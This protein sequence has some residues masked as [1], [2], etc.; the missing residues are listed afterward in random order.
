MNYGI[1]KV[2]KYMK[3]RT[4]LKQLSQLRDI[5]C[6]KY[7]QKTR[8]SEILSLSISWIFSPH[9]SLREVLIFFFSRPNVLRRFLGSK[10]TFCNLVH[11]HDKSRTWASSSFP[12]VTCYILSIIFCC[13][14]SFMAAVFSG[15]SLAFIPP[16]FVPFDFCSQL[17]L[18]RSSFS[19]PLRKSSCI[20]LCNLSR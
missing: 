8:L 10:Y 13:T 6:I 2:T 3:I 16:I 5:R 18:I 1:D 7:I 20:H 9:N 14:K 11:I 15:W 17:C 19:C 12:L 4:A